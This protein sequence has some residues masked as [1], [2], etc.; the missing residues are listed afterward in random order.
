MAYNSTKP[1]KYL[2]QNFLRDESALEKTIKAA[3]INKSDTVVEIG[4][5]RGVLTKRLAREAGRVIAVEKDKD[6]IPNLKK[7]LAEFN[8]V[9]IF[10]EDILKFLATF[11]T[12]DY[13]IVANIPYYLTAR[14][15]RLALERDNPPRRM[16]LMVQ[17]EVA[18]RICAKPP[19]MTLLA[20][21]IQYFGRPKI[22]SIVKKGAFWPQPQ[23]DSAII[24]IE[25]IKK[26]PV[27]ERRIFFM[28]ARA[29]F[30]HPRKFALN[31]LAQ[32]LKI[33]K[34]EAKKVLLREKINPRARAQDIKTA[35]W[36]KIAYDLK[37]FI[38]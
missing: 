26:K 16:T 21:S 10:K 34:N 8:N 5:G 35:L 24:N 15:L 18:Q 3:E 4:P 32:G 20:A 29:G 12:G 19:K 33:K 36:E 22:V 14:L 2:G 37:K 30:A 7:E 31:N 38:V 27:D 25:D 9:E 1:K 6:L 28:A 13:K 23:V 17:K 11:K